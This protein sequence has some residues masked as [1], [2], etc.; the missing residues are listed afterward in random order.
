VAT[1][2]QLKKE[3]VEI[4]RRIYQKGFVAANDGN[5]STRLDDDRIL[6]TPTGVSKGFMN[7]DEMIICDMKGKV[8]SDNGKPSSEIYMHL[9]VYEERN[10]VKGIVHAHPPYATAFGVAGIP[11]KQAILPEVIILLGGI[12][13]AEY[14]TPGTEEIFKPLLKHLKN[15]N[16]FLLQN[17]GAL[18]IGPDMM[19]AYFRMETLEHCAHITFLSHLLGS[20]HTLS[21]GDVEKLLSQRKKYGLTGE[22]APQTCTTQDDAC[23]LLEKGETV[24]SSSTPPKTETSPISEQTVKTLV[25][26]IIDAILK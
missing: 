5:I 22:F 10:D 7:E 17:H 18:A 24:I 3:M 9:K 12:P 2:Y 23:R 15:Y 16:A 19:T 14:G 21:P 8:L 25:S 26:E 4:G 1:L 13:L 6:I 11:L 20:I